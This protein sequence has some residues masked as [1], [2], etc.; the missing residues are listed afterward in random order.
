MLEGWNL[1]LDAEDNFGGTLLGP[2]I[3]GVKWLEPDR[4]CVC[5]AEQV[6]WGRELVKMQ[7]TYQIL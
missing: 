1:V 2:D 5:G 4:V 3:K 6:M 7:T